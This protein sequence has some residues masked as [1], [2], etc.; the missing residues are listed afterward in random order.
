MSYAIKRSGR[1]VK[2]CK[3][4]RSGFWVVLR[5][6]VQTPYLSEADRFVSE[7]T[8]CRKLNK[9]NKGDASLRVRVDHTTVS[10]VFVVLTHSF[11]AT[12]PSG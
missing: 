10:D 12:I 8:M 11:K 5:G 7:H 9:K 3:E 6:T 2:H 1:I 4:D